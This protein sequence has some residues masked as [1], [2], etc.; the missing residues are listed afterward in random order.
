MES[1]GVQSYFGISTRFLIIAR[2][3]FVASILLRCFERLFFFVSFYKE[4]PGIYNTNLNILELTNYSLTKGSILLVPI[5]YVLTIFSAIIFLINKHFHKSNLFLLFSLLTISALDGVYIG[6][7][8]RIIWPY[9]IFFFCL[10][11]VPLSKLNIINNVKY[12]NPLVNLSLFV[13]ASAIYFCSFYFKTDPTWTESRNALSYFLLS[14]QWS[15]SW[16]KFLTQY[17]ELLK[18]LT[19]SSLILEASAPSLLIFAVFK[20]IKASV[21]SKSIL[22]ISFITFHLTIGI[23]TVLTVFSLAMIS[24]WA[25]FLD[26][27]PKVEVNYFKVNP[28]KKALIGL[29]FISLIAWN[30]F[31][32][33][34]DR[35]PSGS[36][37]RKF[38][39]VLRSYTIPQHWGLV[40][41]APGFHNYEV[42]TFKR[43]PSRGPQFLFSSRK[44]PQ[45]KY[46]AD[47]FFTSAYLEQSLLEGFL[48]KYCK[49]ADEVL[50]FQYH[51]R[52]I[53]VI[54]KE[55][56]PYKVFKFTKKC[57]DYVKQL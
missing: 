34:L 25:L 35:I 18:F 50:E 27:G 22:A 11:K 21:A 38:A 31:P 19:T 29:L 16:T 2:I 57:S 15:L 6:K 14:D 41:P 28:L 39:E 20:N 55:D 37:E 3:L 32:K 44:M 53:D 10:P 47:A 56:K 46:F 48:P 5:L 40:A 54:N 17:P 26:T 24:F 12:Y 51:K 13:F 30:Y 33:N 9:L 1:L 8:L 23:A 43:F 7:G 4:I 52:K 49:D 42:L 45:G 36:I